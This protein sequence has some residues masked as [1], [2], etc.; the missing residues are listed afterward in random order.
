[1]K[2]VSKAIIEESGDDATWVPPLTPK[3]VGKA[4]SPFEK[5]LA[6]IVREMKVSWKSSE[7]IAQD[8]LEVSREMLCQMM[9]LVDLVELVV[10]GK[11]L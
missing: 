11:C 8:A 5:A 9:A 4:E 10:Q 3:V 6:G 7:K 1:M 2:V